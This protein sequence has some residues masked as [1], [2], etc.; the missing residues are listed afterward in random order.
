MSKFFIYRPRFAWVIAIFISLAGLLA[1]RSLPVSQYPDVAPPQVMVNATYPGASAEVLNNSVASI[2]EEELNGAKGLLYFESSSDSTGSAGITATFKPGTDPDLALVDVQNRLKRVEARLPQA[3]TQ[4]GLQVEQAMSS[5]LL[6]YT[7]GAENGE[8][9]AATLA[10]FAV[11]SVNNEIRRIPGVGRVM[12]FGGEKAMRIW[13]DPQKLSSFGLSVPDVNRAILAQN[14]QIAAGN[15]ADLPNQGVQEITASIQ[16]N[17]QLNSVEEFSRIVLKALPSGSNV[18]LGDIARIELGSQDY[19]QSTTLNGKI[20]AGVAVQL[21]PGANALETARSVKAK[22]AEL[23]RSFPKGYVYAVPYDTSIFVDAAISK[24]VHTLG[25]AMVLVFLVM[26]LFLQNFRYTLIPMIVVPVSLLGTLAV[27]LPLGFSVNMMTMFGMVL[28]I[29]ILVDDAIVVVENVERLMSEEGLDPKHATLKAMKQISGAIVGITLVLTAVFLPLAFMNGS[30]GVIYRQFSISLAISILFSGFLALTLTPALSAT[31]IK[32]VA[33][34][35]HLERKGFYG[36]FNRVFRKLT[37]GFNDSTHILLRRTGRMMLLYI[38]LVILLAFS[39]VK[40]PSG[41]LPTEDQGYMITSVQ[42][43]STASTSRTL[44]INKEVERFFAERPEVKNVMSIAGFGF[45]GNG[46]NAVTSYVVFN[47]WSSRNKAQST[48]AVSGEANAA[49]SGVK[50]GTVF[51]VVPPAIDSM[52]NSSG[53]SLRLQDRGSLGHQA[54]RAA[55]DQLLAMV[56]QSS[57]IA[58]VM[59]EGLGDAPQIELAIDREK[60]AAMGVGIDT[61]NATLSTAFASTLTNEFPNAGRMQRVIVQAESVA[62]QT[63]EDIARLKVA[64]DKGDLVPMGAFSTSTW[65]MKPIQVVRY[66]GYLTLRYAGDVRPGH[67]TGEAMQEIESLIAKLPKGIGYEWTGISYQEKASGAQAPALLAL[68]LLVVFLL[69]VALYESWSIPAAVLLIVPIGALGSVAIAHIFSLANDVYFKVALVT[70][71][72]LSAKNAI[73]IVEFAKDLHAQGKTLRAAATEA[74]RIRF[75][76]IVMTSFA[77]ILG[78]L[79]LAFAS[80]AGAAS[81]RSI[82]LDVFG[83][84]LSASVLG[85]L[86]VPVF[87]VWVLA[88]FGRTAHKTTENHVHK[89]DHHA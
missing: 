39:Y 2:I 12:M 38:G 25:E 9:D 22:L 15:L 35:H 87:F 27:M 81:Q 45:S 72:G 73:L 80:G 55:G 19:R 10:D 20:V 63:P 69:L 24:V 82:G 23:S 65:K 36:W 44:T 74:A 13:V 62:R 5:F 77:F 83:G 47:D 21:A 84:M 59:P 50:E 76:P 40:L 42:L 67:S 32:P 43:P 48:M 28:A 60:A 34:G 3:V 49:L 8:K 11:R 66:N 52:G 54:L 88:R 37:A 29:G 57:V 1:I 78:V 4:Q 85:V 14:I 26:L 30:V 17:G 79:P 86:F 58:Y 61:I 7:I 53:F 75:R 46:Q 16:A 6:M 31:L 89:A 51:A 56:A 68:S 64:N 18:V 70:I 33:K 41:F 71:I